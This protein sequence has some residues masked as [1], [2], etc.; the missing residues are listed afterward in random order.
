MSSNTDNLSLKQATISNTIARFNK[1]AHSR[2]LSSLS[3]SEIVEIK[4]NY[5][6]LLNKQI[7]ELVSLPLD[8]FTLIHIVVLEELKRVYFSQ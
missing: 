6:N 3:P 4:N 8:A 5:L 2:D 1:Y 7:D